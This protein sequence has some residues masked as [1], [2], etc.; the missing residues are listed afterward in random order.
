MEH[1]ERV[2]KGIGGEWRQ[3]KEMGGG[4]AKGQTSHAINT[5]QERVQHTLFPLRR[6]PTAKEAPISRVESEE[7]HM[8]TLA[9][10]ESE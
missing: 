5:D 2:E 3:R 7:R 1:A 8:H 9:C 6:A 10:G 4:Q